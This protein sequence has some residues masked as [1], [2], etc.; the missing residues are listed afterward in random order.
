MSHDISWCKT[1]KY[2][3][4]SICLVLFCARRSCLVG[5]LKKN[6]TAAEYSS[7]SYDEYLFEREDARILLLRYFTEEHLA[8]CDFFVMAVKLYIHQHVE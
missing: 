5:I 4:R 7:F 6:S 1:V 8:R 3:R 2:K